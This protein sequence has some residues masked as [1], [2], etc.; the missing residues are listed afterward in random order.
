MPAGGAT[1][2]GPRDFA[3]QARI[4]RRKFEF[5][6][7]PFDRISAQA[8][9][10]CGGLLTPTETRW[11]PGNDRHRVCWGVA[12]RPR[13]TAPPM[14]AGA[15][16]LTAD[17]RQFEILQASSAP[18]IS[19]HHFGTDFDLFDPDLNPAL[20]EAGQ[21]F[22]DEFSWLMRNASTYGF[23]QTFTPTSTFMRL[24]Y[25]EERWH[26]SYYPVA[27]ALVDFARSHVSDVET[28]LFR[29]WGT[30][31]RFSFIRNHW[32]EFFFNVNETA[33]F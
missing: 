3:H 25:I 4:W 18:G 17:E 20:W 31:A 19:R 29:Q 10:I 30:Q 21:P 23:I 9:G 15:R 11:D 33:R 27:Q 2:S 16:A 32:R 1:I 13:R 14:P 24:G 26:W 8:R 6:G 7:T 12:P 22:A 5:R 28:A